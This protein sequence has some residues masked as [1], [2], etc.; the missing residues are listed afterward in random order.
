[1]RTA[2][3]FLLLLLLAAVGIVYRRK[4]DTRTGDLRLVGGDEQQHGEKAPLRVA[5]IFGNNMVLPR[6]QPRIWG[7]GEPGSKICSSSDGRPDNG[8]YGS[9]IADEAGFWMIENPHAQGDH[10]VIS[11]CY[12]LS[13]PIYLRDVAF[14]EVFL[15]SGQSNME[16]SVGGVFNKTAEISDSINYPNLRLFT[17]ARA[18]SDSPKT[19]LESKANYTW[20]KS[21]PDAM[22]ATHEFSRFS[23]AC[24]FFGREYYKSLG[25][26]VPIGLISSS[27][28][29]QNVETFSSH[30]ALGDLSCGGTQPP[31]P[32]NVH[33]SSDELLME[34]DGVLPNPNVTQ[35]WN[36]MIHPLRNFR[37]SGVVWYQGEAN[38]GNATSY[39]CR[40]P[41]MITDWRRKF[42]SPNLPF[43]Y[44]QLAA[45][46][47]ADYSPIRAAQDAALSLRNVGAA[48]A[49]DL[50][51]PTSPY[52]SIHSRRKQ[53]VG[54]RLFLAM[55]AIKYSNNLGFVG[56]GP[57]LE[58]VEFDPTRALSTA[59]LDFGNAN[60]LHLEGTA[61]CQE[62]CYEPPF[63][64]LD[65]YGNWTRVLQAT[66][67]ENK[68]KLKLETNTT[69]LG[70]RYNWEGFPQCALY[71]GNGGPDDHNG[72]P[73]A[74]FEWCVYPSGQGSWAKD[75]ACALESS[76]QPIDSIQ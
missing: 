33:Q 17:V 48:I 50:G 52:G 8:G 6:D 28:G 16:M 5:K 75:G 30:D 68:V 65:P 59:V 12:D 19:D 36:A 70:I 63:E 61:A 21:G 67:S 43:A 71:N 38:A 25:G 4:E 42:K 55:R 20:G 47:K 24:Y 35:L 72:V 22:D 37:F 49:I 54:R 39:A 2:M 26:K 23:A 41:A 11:Y 58:K 15:C 66:V 51:D 69:I 53:E 18:I 1:M 62:C 14:G 45:Y 9:T 40:F 46:D 31:H 73:T 27:W 57:I 32:P 74:P 10:L 7:W 44:V 64:G 3:R 29:G 56:T 13:W 34:E 60:G 76:I